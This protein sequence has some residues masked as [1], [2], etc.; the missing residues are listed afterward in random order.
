MDTASQAPQPVPQQPQPSN[1]PLNS[2]NL[3]QPPQKK[4]F[5]KINLK[6]LAVLFVGLFIIVGLV[7]GSLALAYE[8][9]SINNPQIEEAVSNFVLGLPFTPKTPK[10]IIRQAVIAH[11]RVAKHGFDISAVSKSSS[12]SSIF[13]FNELDLEAKGTVDYSDP[14]NI[15]VGLNASLS[16]DLNLDLLVKDKIT[17]I[18]INKYPPI[19]TSFLRIDQEKIKPVLQNWIAFD[20]TP[21]ETNARKYIDETSSSKTN[22]TEDFLTKIFNVLLDERLIEQIKI[23]EEKLDDKA[24]YKFS[25][26]PDQQLTSYL[27]NKLNDE[28]YNGA[29]RLTVDGSQPSDTIKDLILDVWL[30]KNESYISQ[31]ATSFKLKPNYTPTQIPTSVLGITSLMDIDSRS[32]PGIG[33]Q[34]I[35]SVGTAE[36]EVASVIKFF[37]FG[38]EVEIKTPKKSMKFEEF[39]SEVI[40]SS[41]MYTDNPYQASASAYLSDPEELTKRGRD[42]QRLVDLANL[43]QAINVVA[44]ESETGNV[45]CEGSLSK[46]IP[47]RGDSIKDSSDANGAGWVKVNLNLQ[48]AVSV[49]QIPFDPVN[50]EPYHYTYC[51]Y[52][53][54]WEMNAVLESQQQSPKMQT[55]GGDDLSKYEVGSNL[56][57][58]NKIPQCKF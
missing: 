13:G 57:L 10:Y 16:K 28:N 18:K 56:N 50:S 53:D 45:L 3:T 40:K 49:P 26:K 5:L 6:L 23:N 7:G 38:K 44:Q 52:K 42:A 19:I 20:N 1:P 51:A 34:D 9:I 11:K 27:I 25:L 31:V 36:S 46:V 43:Q 47:C 39:Y 14:K 24:M 54:T 2:S 33:T 35:Y 15:K 29:K 48:K 32:Q 21:L 41:G 22:L 58:I 17:Y 37:D 55:D 8:K 12:Y 4:S 30:D